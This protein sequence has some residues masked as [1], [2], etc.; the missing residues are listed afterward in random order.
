MG[1]RQGPAERERGTGREG[2]WAEMEAD[3]RGRAVFEEA[4]GMRLMHR[5]NGSTL[6]LGLAL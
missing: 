3:A 6:H 4:R 5:F 2:E 1:N